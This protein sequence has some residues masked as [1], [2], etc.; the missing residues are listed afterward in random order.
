MLRQAYQWWQE[1]A[2]DVADRRRVRDWE[3]KDV[4]EAAGVSVQ[5]IERGEWTA[6]H[7]LFFV[8]SA[9]GLRIE[10]TVEVTDPRPYPP[11]PADRAAR[12][13]L[14]R[15]AGQDR[16][17]TRDEVMAGR[18]VIT[19]LA[20]HHELLEPSV[21]ADGVLYVRAGRPGFGP[22]WRFASVLAQILGVWVTVKADEDG[23]ADRAE[24]VPL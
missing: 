24:A 9:L 20:R 22:L 5:R 2:K 23:A 15:P 16:V 13:A 3:Q 21:D 6:V 18:A 12:R 1:I 17:A 10:Q 11:A 19:T 4:A 14:A 7:N 8:C